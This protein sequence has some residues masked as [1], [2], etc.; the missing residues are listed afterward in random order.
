MPDS[1][2]AGRGGVCVRA[3]ACFICAG[4]SKT[5]FGLHFAP[6]RPRA[7]FL[8]YPGSGGLRGATRPAPQHPLRAHPS[9]GSCLRGRRAP[10]PSPRAVAW[11]APAR[12]AARVGAPGACV[13]GCVR[14][15]GARPSAAAGV[16][17]GGGRRPS[18]RLLGMARSPGIRWVTGR[19]VEGGFFSAPV[20][21]ISTAPK[22][23]EINNLSKYCVVAMRPLQTKSLASRSNPF[24]AFREP[25][26]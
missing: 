20:V 4:F 10:A 7:E 26:T 12:V 6:H 11:A 2:L 18:P 16:P 24:A 5:G 15:E 13:C 1:S 19:G 14:L 22:P 23:L 21:P 17:G 25:P 9:A 3:C 8:R